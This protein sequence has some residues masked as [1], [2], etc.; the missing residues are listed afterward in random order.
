MYRKRARAAHVLH[1]TDSA[2]AAAPVA[3]G[4]GNQATA[5]GP[6]PPGNVSGAGYNPQPPLVS[7]TPQMQFF[8]PM[9]YQNGFAGGPSGNDP[10]Q[11]PG[12]QL[13][14]QQVGVA[15]GVTNAGPPPQG[16]NYGGEQLNEQQSINQQGISL[17]TIFKLSTHL[18]CLIVFIF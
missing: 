10:H 8:N 7:A 3:A 18:H 9:T 12:A 1:P 14:S 15:E 17:K 2:S 16:F 13:Q 5:A 11:F 6:T 4:Q